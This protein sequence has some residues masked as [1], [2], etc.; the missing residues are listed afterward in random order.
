VCDVQVEAACGRDVLLHKYVDEHVRCILLKFGGARGK[1]R[2]VLARVRVLLHMQHPALQKD[3]IKPCTQP[4]SS[5]T[6]DM[7]EPGARYV[8]Y[9]RGSGSSCSTIKHKWPA[10]DGLH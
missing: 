6:G 4:R 5:N 2:G 3:M 7:Q 1:V 10:D 8:E 9:L